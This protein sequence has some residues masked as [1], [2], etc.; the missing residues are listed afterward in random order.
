MI[1]IWLV[2][3]FLICLLN[4]LMKLSRAFQRGL[5]L[6]ISSL[7]QSQNWLAICFIRMRLEALIASLKK[8]SFQPYFPFSSSFFFTHVI[9]HGKI[10]VSKSYLP[11]SSPLLLLPGRQWGLCICCSLFLKHSFSHLPPM[12]YPL[13]SFRSLKCHFVHPYMVSLHHFPDPL[14]FIIVHHNS[15]L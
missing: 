13:T 11:T 6:V 7:T 2:F 9:L 3:T 4:A 1:L 15:S 5:F 12:S 14:S 8:K 10:P